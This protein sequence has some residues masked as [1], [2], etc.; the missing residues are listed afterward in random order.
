MIRNYY[1]ISGEMIFFFFFTTLLLLA[2]KLHIG[3]TMGG[4]QRRRQAG[5]MSAG[6]TGSGVAALGSSVELLESNLW[7]FYI[8]FS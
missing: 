5:H 8:Q 1:T 3:G 2:V 7:R 4:Q 6:Q